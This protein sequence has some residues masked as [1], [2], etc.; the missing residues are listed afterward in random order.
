MDLGLAGAAV[1]VQGGSKG[2]GRAAAE[3]FAADGARVVI[4]ARG[5]EAIDETV[6]GCCDKDS[7]E[8]SGEAALYLS[9]F[10]GLLLLLRRR[11]S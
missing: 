11:R 8:E 1:C 7:A 4:L 5:K 2:M 10:L 3:A 6:G 9:P